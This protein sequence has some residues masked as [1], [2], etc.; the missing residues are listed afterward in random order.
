[1]KRQKIY[2]P[3]SAPVLELLESL[4]FKNFQTI[5]YFLEN[6]VEFLK[7]QQK[8]RILERCLKKNKPVFSEVEQ[9]LK[10]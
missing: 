8:F 4:N 10:N 2:L 9:K 5:Y 3:D 1:M 6:K 7:I